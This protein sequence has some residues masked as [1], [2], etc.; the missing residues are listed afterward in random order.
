[1]MRRQI[2]QFKELHGVITYGDQYR[3][4]DPFQ[5]ADMAA[6]MF[7]SEDKTEALVQVVQM[8]TDPNPPLR[9]IRL[10][11]LD[12]SKRYREQDSGRILSGQAWMNAG[13]NIPE[14]Y[15]DGAACIFHLLALEL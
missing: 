12:P 14:M 4:V 1:M 15:G 2:Q 11:G 7:V 8:R 5:D 10:Q 13:I 9:R 6:W 3:L